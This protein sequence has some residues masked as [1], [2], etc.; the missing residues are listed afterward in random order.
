[1]THAPMTRSASAAAPD[2]HPAPAAS[3]WSPQQLRVWRPA[4][5]ITVSQWAARHRIVTEGQYLGPWTNEYAPYLREPMDTWCLPHVRKVIL[6]FAPQTG[7][8]QIALNCLG[9][10]IDMAPGPAMYIMPTEAKAKDFGNGKL[11]ALIRKT[12]RLAA[13]LSPRSDDTT[14]LQIRFIHGMRLMVAW[15]NSPAALSSESIEYLFFDETDKY[16]VFSG[17]E[18]DPISLGEV[19]TTAYPYTKKIMYFST[20][21]S[22]T[23]VISRAVENEADVVMEYYARCPVCGHLQVM[24]FENIHWPATIRDPRTM[25]RNRYARYECESCKFL[26]DDNQRNVAVAQGEWRPRLSESGPILRPISV[27]YVL[28]AW[29]SRNTSLSDSAAAY[30]RGLHDMSKKMAFVTQHKAEPWKLVVQT[31]SE[32]E[33][34]K[35]KTDLPPQVVPDEAVALTLGVDAQKSGFW[36]VVRAWARDYTSWLIHYGELQDWSEIE[37]MIFRKTYLRRSDPGSALPI[38]RAAIDTGGTDTGLGISM[39]EAAYWWL[40]TNVPKAVSQGR[41]IWG[42]KGASHTI[43]GA[44]KLGE[45]LLKT[46]SG[47]RLPHWLRLVLID[48][49]FMKD[50]YHFHLNQAAN[51]DPRGAYLHAETGKDYVRQI[52]AEEKRKNR[53]GVEEWVRIRQDNHLL[54]AEIL[55]MSLAH[56]QWP[57]GGVNLV[58]RPYQ[59][60]SSPATPGTQQTGRRVI[61]QGSR[62]PARSAQDFKRPSWTDR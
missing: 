30:L 9:Y 59:P 13:L 25:E 52:L 12:P 50:Q 46:P 55:A 54:D 35:A 26:W 24:I 41:G 48:T 3:I 38:W 10:A 4:E 20:P 29:Y 62:D 40:V 45:E 32:V 49:Q 34:L 23:G 22:E 6:R 27:A 16:D 31:S 7:K 43:P 39:T 37:E 56:Y 17:R 8:T 44:F 11:D 53:K 28:P 21:E 1:M 58:S 19:R 2:A 60:G 61:S 5:K 51:A 57:G 18:S 33:I 14:T 15:A 47:K 36:F 42:T